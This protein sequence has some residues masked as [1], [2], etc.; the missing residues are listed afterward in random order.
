[1]IRSASVSRR[2]THMGLDLNVEGRAKPGHEAEWRAILTR[3]FAEKP[4]KGDGE[5]YGEISI[6]SY[7]QVGAPQVGHDPAADAWIIAEQQAT[8]PEE[9]AATLRKFDGHYA[10][11]LVENDGLP[12]YAS[13]HAGTDETTFRGKFLELCDDVLPRE[14]FEQAWEHKFPEQAIAY[15]HALLAAADSA[16]ANGPL[17]ILPPPPPKGIFALLFPPRAE[18][19]KG[20]CNLDEQLDIVRAAG[21]WFLFWGERQNAIVAWY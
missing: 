8:T 9:V 6:P 10:L 13:R 5:R 1:M 14:L 16:E 4:R 18:E 19:R 15:G 17:P 2:G 7:A 20:E 12:K 11:P 3:S 21:R